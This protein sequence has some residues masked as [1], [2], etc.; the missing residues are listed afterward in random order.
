MTRLSCDEVE[1]LLA[2]RALDALPEE[3]ARR[4]DEHVATCTEHAA[5]LSDLRRAV[6][7]L[8]LAVDDREPPAGLRDRILEAVGRES[9]VPPET[10][11]PLPTGGPPTATSRR[12]TARWQRIP[13]RL[14]VAAALLLA[15]GAGYVAGLRFGQAGLQTWSFTGNQLAP[16]AQA[17]LVYAPA[18]Q[19]AVLTAT[20][21]PSLASGHVYEAWLIR[22][23]TPVGIGTSDT[24]GKLVLRLSRDLSGYQVVAITIEPGVQTRPTTTP[25]LAGNL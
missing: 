24:D 15:L 7:V 18:Q 9:P 8:P 16:Q 19:S 13:A 10:A 1:S 25:V 12:F 11:A 5:V 14:M 20:G 3:D 4:V 2:S 6:A 17:T 22:G 23:G 21:L